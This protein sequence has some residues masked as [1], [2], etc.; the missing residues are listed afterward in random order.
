MGTADF[1]SRK[2][3]QE[4]KVRREQLV[5]DLRAI[6]ERVRKEVEDIRSVM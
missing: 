1:P 6:E 5:V 3:S 4:E 2:L